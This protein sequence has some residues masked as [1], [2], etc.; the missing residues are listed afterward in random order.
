L[1]GRF[2][3]RDMLIDGMLPP[4]LLSVRPSI[5]NTWIRKTFEGWIIQ[6]SPCSSP[7]L[8]I[9]ARLVSSRNSNW[10]PER[11]SDK[12]EVDKISYFLV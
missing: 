6:F 10:F 7:I 1:K 2:L 9:F 4:F 5:R 3:A 11:A 8:L 12:G